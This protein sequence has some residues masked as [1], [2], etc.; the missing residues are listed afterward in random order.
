VKR[1]KSGGEGGRIWKKEGEDDGPGRGHM[2]A[3][4]RRKMKGNKEWGR[5]H[6]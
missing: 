3:V 1:R 5:N 6:L 4:E 2:E